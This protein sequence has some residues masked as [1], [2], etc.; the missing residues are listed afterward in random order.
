M[1]PTFE[2]RAGQPGH[3]AALAA[4]LFPSPEPLPSS[5]RFASSQTLLFPS[6]PRVICTELG[7]SWGAALRLYQD[8]WLSFSPETSLQLDEAQEA[9]LRFLGTLVSAG[10][11][12]HMLTLLLAGLSRPYAYDLK[13]LFFDWS[14]RRW[15]L[16]SETRGQ[17]EA[18]FADWVEMLAQTGDTGSLTGIVEVAQE[19]LAHVQLR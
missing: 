2:S 5:T 3:D 19:A 14:A 12:Q 8:G 6:S 1:D 11:D 17:P 4:L 7:L 18:A 15:R 10:C 16:L 13:R 9:E